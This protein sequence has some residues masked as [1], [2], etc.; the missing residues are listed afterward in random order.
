MPTFDICKGGVAAEC[1][2]IFIDDNTVYGVAPDDRASYAL[3]LAGFFYVANAED[4]RITIPNTIPE[5]VAQWEVPSASDGYYYFDLI[6]VIIWD[7]GD[8]YLEGDVRYQNGSYWKSLQDANTDKTP[9]NEPTW[10][11]AVADPYLEKDSL[12]SASA[13]SIADVTREDSFT[14]CRADICYKRVVHDAAKE[15]CA[16][17][18]EFVSRNLMRVDSLVQDAYML[19]AQTRYT[20]AH[21]L[22]LLL[23]DVCNDLTDCGCP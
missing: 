16:K 22:A 7:S 4:S 21:K 11:E 1:G 15:S 17:C 3:F 23:Q 10:W 14:L 13:A 19:V 12:N 9:T 5:T 8:T 18:D 20:E 6:P 2:S